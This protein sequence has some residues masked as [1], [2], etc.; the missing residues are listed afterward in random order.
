MDDELLDVGSSWD[1][2]VRETFPEGKLVTVTDS[3]SPYYLRG[4]VV[5]NLDEETR[6]IEVFFID[7]PAVLEEFRTWQLRGTK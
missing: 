5:K 3:C 2:V 4:G 7:E 6:T 1:E